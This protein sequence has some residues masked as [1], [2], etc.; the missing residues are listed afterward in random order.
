MKLSTKFF[1]YFTAIVLFVIGSVAIF[2]YRSEKKFR[3]AQLDQH[4]TDYN[5]TINNFI[6]QENP[7]IEELSDFVTLFADSALRVTVIDSVGNVLYDSMLPDSLK[8]ENHLH[9]PEISMSVLSN[10]GKSIRHS[11]TTDEDY[12]YLAIRYPNHFV[13]S[14]LPYN[15]SLRH[16]LEANT[17]FIYFLISIFFISF[18]L[19][20]ALVFK[21]NESIRRLRIFTQQAKEGEISSTELDFS[22]DELGEI[23]DTIVQLY[24]E[25]LRLKNELSKEH[26]KLVNHLQISQEG[27]GIFTKD[28]EEILVNSHFIQYVSI[29][30]DNRKSETIFSSPDFHPITRFIDQNQSS[31]QLSRKRIVIEKNGRTFI[32]LCIVFQDDSFEISISDISQQ[33]QENEL[34]RQLT[35]NISHELK[36]P[37]SSILGYMESILQNPDLDPDKKMFFIERSHQQALRLNALLQDISTLNKIDEAKRLYIKEPCYIAKIVKDV[38]NDVQLQMTKANCTINQ[39]IG[40]DVV[41]DGNQSLLYSVFQNLINNSL[42]Y[43]GE[44]MTRIDISCYREDKEFYY[45]S[46]S[47]NGTGVGQEHLPRLFER[48]YRVDKGRDRKLGGT[49]LGL[50]IVKNAIVFHNGQISAKNMPEGG[51]G[52]L[53]TLKKN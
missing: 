30:C 14:A 31:G 25:Q 9:R 45:F 18:I 8:I 46:F 47:D 49:G 36:T 27:I 22:N 11:S 43:G 13:R 2:Q 17:S 16:I 15:A 20:I 50:A 5:N 35:Q 7:T 41:I 38:V 19:I 28:K 40:Q 44:N 10:S 42:A 1:I 21:L 23:S 33:E 39:S 26:E 6:N 3:V 4:L 37:V 52:L 29:L 48:F 32:V 34:K 51:L 24:G 12:Y 53:F